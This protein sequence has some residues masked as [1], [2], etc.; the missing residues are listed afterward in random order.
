[1]PQAPRH[2]HE[3]EDVKRHEGNVKAGDPEPEGVAAITFV[4]CKTENFREPIV[5]P[6]EQTEQNP[7][8]QHVMKMCNEEQ[9][10]MQHIIVAGIA[11]ITPLMPPMVKVMMKPRV[12][13][14]GTVRRKRPR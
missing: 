11:R 4:Q 5:H 2:A 6:G 13:N 7:A 3:T 14:T 1:M 10:V 12:H 8:D 9:A